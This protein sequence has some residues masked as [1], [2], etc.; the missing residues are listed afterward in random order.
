[1]SD[2]KKEIDLGSVAI[3][4]TTTPADKWLCKSCKAILAHVDKNRETMRIKYK[5]LYVYVKG[6]DV[7]IIC[8]GCG[9]QNVASQSNGQ[10]TP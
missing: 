10:P 8:R 6:G 9:T 4:T 3:K 2:I 7:T 5:D 1:M